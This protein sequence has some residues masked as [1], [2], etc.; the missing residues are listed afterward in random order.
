MSGMA[1]PQF[2]GGAVTSWWKRPGSRDGRATRQGTVRGESRPQCRQVVHQRPV[3]RAAGCV[4]RQVG[5]T[6]GVSGDSAWPPPCGRN[7]CRNSTCPPTKIG[8]RHL[9]AT[10]QHTGT[11]PQTADTTP[12]TPPTG[13]C[14]AVGSTIVP[15]GLC[16]TSA[17]GHSISG[18]SYQL[19]TGSDHRAMGG[20]FT[21]QIARRL[22]CPGDRSGCQETQSITQ[23]SLEPARRHQRDCR[24]EVGLD[25]RTN[26]S[27]S[28]PPGVAVGCRRCSRPRPFSAVTGR[29]RRIR[30]SSQRRF[31]A[32]ELAEPGP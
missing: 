15:S 7:G 2:V 28:A 18:R 25:V 21:T 23:T 22:G 11:A 4:L 26:G 13:N 27:R 5:R 9:S 20:Q 8:L 17:P 32:V 31:D 24:A 16:T 1:F 29:S 19:R 30:S 12:A 3:W 10:A 6:F 14:R